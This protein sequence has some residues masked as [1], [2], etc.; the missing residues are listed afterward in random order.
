MNN[1]AIIS[2]KKVGLMIFL[3]ILMVVAVVAIAGLV[4]L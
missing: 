2:T 1:K 4:S 3:Y